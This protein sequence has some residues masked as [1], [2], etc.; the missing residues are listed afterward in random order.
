MTTKPIFCQSLNFFILVEYIFNV[1]ISIYNIGYTYESKLCK[2][3]VLWVFKFDEVGHSISTKSK[4]L[5]VNVFSVYFCQS[6]FFFD[7]TTPP[8]GPRA[9][10]NLN[11]YSDMIFSCLNKQRY[12]RKMNN[13]SFN[14]GKR[15]LE[16]N[17]LTTYNAK[18]LNSRLRWHYPTRMIVFLNFNFNL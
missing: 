8:W 2:T 14:G 13:P 16:K 12:K 9:C 17:L 10:A 5:Y 3:K 6:V 18:Y 7:F 15:L 1:Y 4:S 11:Q